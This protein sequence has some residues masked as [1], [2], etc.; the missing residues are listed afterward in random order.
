MMLFNPLK[1]YEEI[2]YN[3]TVFEM[4]A[5]FRMTFFIFFTFSILSKNLDDVLTTQGGRNTYEACPTM[6]IVI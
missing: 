6:E 3:P 5:H 2:F 1:G 4:I